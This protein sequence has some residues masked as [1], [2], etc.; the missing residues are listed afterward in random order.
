M[1]SLREKSHYHN[2]LKVKVK[3][4]VKKSFLR[5]NQDYDTENIFHEQNAHIFSS[6][7][8]VKQAIISLLVCF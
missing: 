6:L 7:L 4:N 5:L 8:E 3:V 1:F 2:L